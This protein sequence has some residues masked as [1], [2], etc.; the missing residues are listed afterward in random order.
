MKIE[1]WTEFYT[2]ANKIISDALT[3]VKSKDT[4]A[5]DRWCDSD[6][7]FIGFYPS[8]V[9]FEIIR[10]SGSGWNPVEKDEHLVPYNELSF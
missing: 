6:Y 9:G 7:I 8:G 3:I 1:E 2:K 4:V 5:A 10:Y